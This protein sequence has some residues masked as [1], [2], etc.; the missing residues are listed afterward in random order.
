VNNPQITPQTLWPLARVEHL[1]AGLPIP[2]IALPST[3]GGVVALSA[4]AGLSVVY[5]YPWTGRPGVANPPNWDHIPGAHGSTPQAAG[6][7]A[8][9]AGFEALGARVIGIS[10]Q[11]SS[12]QSEFSARLGL[13]FPLLSDHELRLARALDLPTFETGGTTYLSRMTLIVRDGRIVQ[14]HFPVADPA[15]HAS[16]ILSDLKVQRSGGP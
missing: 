3:A 13:T 4:L 1:I 10:G 12:D 11:T 7:T 15:G 2:P 5:L 16:A 14:T 6:F 9:M 8:Q